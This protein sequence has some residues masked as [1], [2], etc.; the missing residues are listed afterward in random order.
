MGR[1]GKTLSSWSLCEGNMIIKKLDNEKYKGQ[2]Y[3]TD[4]VSDI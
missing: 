4:I 1:F 3:R 2:K